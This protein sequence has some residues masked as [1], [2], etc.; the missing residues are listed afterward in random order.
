MDA[1]NIASADLIDRQNQ[2]VAVPPLPVRDMWQL[3]AYKYPWWKG[4]EGA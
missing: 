3:C 1:L 2:T 4:D